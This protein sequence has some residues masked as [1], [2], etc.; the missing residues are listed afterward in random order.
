MPLRV[1]ASLTQVPRSPHPGWGLEPPTVISLGDERPWVQPRK[2]F[3][4]L[5]LPI[6][7]ELWAL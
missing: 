1:H 5:P 2:D 7:V 6:A 4:L 3:Q